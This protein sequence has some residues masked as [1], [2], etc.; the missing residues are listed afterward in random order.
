MFATFLKETSMKWCVSIHFQGLRKTILWEAQKPGMNVKEWGPAVCAHGQSHVEN[1][2]LSQTHGNLA[3]VCK[4][5][6]VHCHI[7]EDA[8]QF[9]KRTWQHPLHLP[10]S[11]E[12]VAI[13]L[14]SQEWIPHRHRIRSFLGEQI[15]QLGFMRYFWFYL[16]NHK[17]CA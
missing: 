4:P 17:I 6:I 7:P 14:G 3:H 2:C 5:D 10:H 11:E 1:R 13:G 15:L 9:P 8:V 12:T 16:G